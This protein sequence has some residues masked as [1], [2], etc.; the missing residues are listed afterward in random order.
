MKKKALSS[1]DI[2]KRSLSEFLKEVAEKHK[3]SIESLNLHVD[4]STLRIQKYTPSGYQEFEQLE[5]L[6]LIDL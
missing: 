6:E 5:T 2:F 3:T 4:G 1:K